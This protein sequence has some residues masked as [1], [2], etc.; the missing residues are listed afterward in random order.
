MEY[1]SALKS[2]KVAGTTYQGTTICIW[3]IW[4]SAT[5]PNL[6]LLTVKS[7]APYGKTSVSKNLGT[8]PLSFN[9]K[10]FCESLLLKLCLIVFY[11]LSTTDVYITWFMCLL[12]IFNKLFSFI[13]TWSFFSKFNVYSCNESLDLKFLIFLSFI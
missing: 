11:P 7:L 2:F 12:L 1:I 8:S 4:S 13:A 6:P 10:A 5:F 9:N 3:S